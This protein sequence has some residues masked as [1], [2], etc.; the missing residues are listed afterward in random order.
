MNV[1]CYYIIT[2]LFPALKKKK[3]E[4]IE[5]NY[6]RSNTWKYKSLFLLMDVVCLSDRK[7]EQKRKRA[8]R[9]EPAL[10]IFSGT[11]QGRFPAASLSSSLGGRSEMNSQPSD[12]LIL[13]PSDLKRSR[14]WGISGA[15]TTKSS[16]PMSNRSSGLATGTGRP[17]EGKFRWLLPPLPLTRP[18]MRRRSQVWP[19]SN[20]G[21]ENHI[22]G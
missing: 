21:S 4:H 8:P 12:W 9:S 1:K 13:E 7:Q 10:Q 15:T 20:R 16:L 22:K 6:T 5:C 14:I 3:E 19:K 11:S 17:R 18:I 2:V